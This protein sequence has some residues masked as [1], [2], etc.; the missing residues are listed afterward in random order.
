MPQEGALIVDGDNVPPETLPVLLDHMLK[1]GPVPHRQI[2]RNWRSTKDSKNW[3]EQSKR[4]AFERVDRYKTTEGKNGSDIA[5]AVAAMDLLHAGVRRFCIASGDTDFA[6]LVERL[7]RGGAHVTIVGHKMDG[8]L[9]SEISDLYLDWKSLMPG[10]RH[11][12]ASPRAPRQ[13][14]T[15]PR[16]P[17]TH[18][19]QAPRA[20]AHPAPRPTPHTAPPRG[21]RPQGRPKPAP[22]PRPTRSAASRPQERPGRTTDG[23]VLPALRSLLLD[24]YEVARTDGEVDAAGW[25]AVDR[26]GQ[27]ARSV[28]PA[29]TPAK[30]GL[31]GRTSL[32]RVFARL[33]EFAV[34]A[35]G[36]SGNRQYRV[37]RVG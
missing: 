32:S 19:R 13:S 9:L 12:P 28:D 2:F 5:V 31:G 8:G 14:R 35:V 36:R 4:L 15:P 17:A 16:A 24:A 37:R 33:P 10:G 7:R 22:A 26:L 1:D 29:F 21:G 20:P 3:D 34:E 6:S 11:T 18:A 25:V 27:L 30:Y 23:A